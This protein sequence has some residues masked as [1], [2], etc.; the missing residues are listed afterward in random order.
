MQKKG[1]VLISGF[2]G[3]V[4]NRF[5]NSLQ[6]RAA[7]I[8][9]MATQI[10]WGLIMIM[11]LDAFYKS[12]TAVP[13][14][15]FRQ[16]CNYVWLGQAFLALLPW[17]FDRGIEQMVRDGR[18]SY[19][20]VR[21]Q[22]VYAVWFAR[23]LGWRTASSFLRAVPLLLFAAFV[24][25]LIGLDNLALSLP[26]SPLSFLSFTAAMFFAVLLGCSIVVILNTT[27][28]WTISGMGTVLIINAAVTIFSG[29]VI[30]LP[31]YP[32]ALQKI[33]AF[34]PFRGLT[35]APFRLYTGHISPEGFFG[36]I[37]HQAV[38]TVLLIIF[39]IRLLE[40]GRARLVVQGG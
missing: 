39:G 10:F 9:G 17:N 11:V 14:I 7:A 4:K 31:L 29:M 36:V 34:L 16:T 18:I 27:L 20:F 13:P 21:P 32:D 37:L 35:D 33:L 19:D 30:P 1:A 38:W 6:Y 5:I 8:A 12:S 2:S 15:S 22:N 24:M 3:I 40:K 28:I 23:A 25:P 26:A